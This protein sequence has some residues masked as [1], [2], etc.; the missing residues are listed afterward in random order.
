MS[1]RPSRKTFHARFEEM[2]K[3]VRSQLVSGHYE[4]GQFLP[5]VDQ[6]AKQFDISINSVRKGLDLL[7]A[8]GLIDILPRVGTRAAERAAESAA[9]LTFGFPSSIYR[10][11]L[12]TQLLER[13]H[14]EHP[15]IHV[16]PIPVEPHQ[17]RE[18]VRTGIPDVLL[19]NYLDFDE[20]VRHDLVRLLDTHTARKEMYP[21]L[22]KRFQA[23]G[24]LYA[25]PFLFSP[26]VL[27]YN[28]R[29][30]REAGLYEP[31]SGW[32]W[33]DLLHHAAVLSDQLG[34]PS[35]FFH[36]SSE[37]RWLVFLLQSGTALKRNPADGKVTLCGTKLM[38]SLSFCR[39]IT[40]NPAIFP[41]GHRMDAQTLFLRERASMIITSYF[42]LNMLKDAPFP[43]DISPLPYLHVPKTLLIMFG[44]A[45][46]G[47]SAHKQ[48]AHT[49]VR[50]LTSERIQQWIAERTFSIPSVKPVAEA[51]ASPE[52]IERLSRYYTFRDIIPTYHAHT[53][54][55]LDTGMI[56][57]MNE[58]LNL[59]WGNMIDEAEL[60]ARLEQ[61]L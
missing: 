35:L 46:H 13:F 58:E 59:F 53:D 8:E 54:L 45:V 55:G 34:R 4:P 10:D 31:D 14:D 60:C 24:E 50:Y 37:N 57:I 22:T 52:R 44:L 6:L 7:A 61:M 48:A 39:S 23:N 42:G 5:T 12:M 32:T 15:H 17:S 36:Y 16:N 1:I 26:V 11:A 41:T 19:V 30:F 3:T 21:F 33:S 40:N 27:C 20:L 56:R 2:V 51:F 28:R 9:V 49:L 47:K 18:F 38:E 29:H 43:F 25:Q